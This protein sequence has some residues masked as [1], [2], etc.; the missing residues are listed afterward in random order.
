M[1]IEP[2]DALGAVGELRDHASRTTAELDGEHRRE[3]GAR[4]AMRSREPLRGEAG[5][6]SIGRRR[7]AIAPVR[8]EVDREVLEQARVRRVVG[9]VFDEQLREA[10]RH[11]ALEDRRHLVANE[12]AR[13]GHDDRQLVDDRIAAAALADHRVAGAI[14]CADVDLILAGLVRARSTTGT[15]QKIRGHMHPTSRSCTP[16]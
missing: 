6:R 4:S 11:V 13:V 10:R 1:Q 14:E 12:R 8:V 7:G 15:N 2:D 16:R 9:Q 3:R 5:A